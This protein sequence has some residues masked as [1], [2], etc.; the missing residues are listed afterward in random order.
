MPDSDLQWKRTGKITLRSE[1]YLI[2]RWHSIYEALH[3]LPGKRVSLGYYPTAAEAQQA[4][5]EH[6]QKEAEAP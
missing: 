4:C 2:I 6:R 3:G 5:M 1:P